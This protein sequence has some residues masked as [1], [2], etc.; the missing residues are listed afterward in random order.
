MRYLSRKLLVCRI[1]LG[2][3]FTPYQRLWLYN[4]APLVAFYDTLGIRRTYS[5]LKP[6]ASSRGIGL[7]KTEGKCQSILGDASC[8]SWRF[9]QVSSVPDHLK[10][11][12]KEFC[13]QSQT[14]DQTFTHIII[15][16]QVMRQNQ[17]NLINCNNEISRGELSEDSAN[18][19]K[20]TTTASCKWRDA[21]RAMLNIQFIGYTLR[22]LED[23]FTTSL[24]DDHLI[25]RRGG[26]LSNFV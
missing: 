9:F 1:R 15:V 24:G 18:L 3:C 4:G 25:L 22:P 14:F 6:P 26:G 12:P 2:Y 5:R 23:N 17:P 21:Q 10:L 11:V 16:T 8:G 7:Q 13:Y 19:L 20:K